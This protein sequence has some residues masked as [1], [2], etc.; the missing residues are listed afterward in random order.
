M[1][2]CRCTKRRYYRCMIHVLLVPCTPAIS[3]VIKTGLLNR[4]T[5]LTMS[6][7][8]R[9]TRV[10]RAA[11][12]LSGT[13]TSCL[14]A[15]SWVSA[16]PQSTDH[17]PVGRAP[18]PPRRQACDA[19][20][21]VPPSPLQRT[22]ASAVNGLHRLVMLLSSMRH[23]SAT[24]QYVSSY[25]QRQG[26]D[27]FTL[28]Y[29]QITRPFVFRLSVARDIEPVL[30]WLRCVSQTGTNLACCSASCSKPFHRPDACKSPAP[31]AC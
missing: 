17:D 15:A 13:R 16:A 5:I 1:C 22:I 29:L 20:V 19:L 25:L 4:I 18:P 10:G 24:T 27:S 21:P 3:K 11:K 30:S 8:S 7:A 28:E 23:T 26:I 31:A 14:H 2:V 6:V 12:E 9:L